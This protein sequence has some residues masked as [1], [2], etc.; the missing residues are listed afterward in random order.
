MST[1]EEQFRQFQAA[2][3]KQPQTFLG[4][5]VTFTVGASLVVLALMFS[6][7]GLMVIAIGGVM[8]GSWLWWKT[9]DVR[10]QMKEQAQRQPTGGHIIEGEIIREGEQPIPSGKLLN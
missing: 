4:K 2:L 1:N 3:S 10:K 8:A 9:R 7:V 6:L 5:V